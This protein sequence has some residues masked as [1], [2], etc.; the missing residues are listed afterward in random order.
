LDCID[1]PS[2]ASKKQPSER[3]VDLQRFSPFVRVW[4]VFFGGGFMMIRGGPPKSHI[5]LAEQNKKL[6]QKL[7]PRV[8]GPPL[9][10]FRIF[11]QEARNRGFWAR[12]REFDLSAPHVS[13]GAQKI[14]K[15]L[16]PPTFDSVLQMWSQIFLAP[17]RNITLKLQPRAGTPPSHC[18]ALL[19]GPLGPLCSVSAHFWT[20]LL[21]LELDIWSHF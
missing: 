4:R 2:N 20:L 18:W 8:L 14:C 16:F 10:T 11:R 13:R 17:P 1:H 15:H 9:E 21:T 12:I 3:E 19:F 6:E 7:S 5:T